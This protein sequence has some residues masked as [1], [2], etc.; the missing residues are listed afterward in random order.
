MSIELNTARFGS[1]QAVNRMEDRAL[2]EGHGVYTDDVTLDRQTH[3]LFLRSTQAHA[4]IVSIDTAAARAMPGVLLVVTGAELTAAGVRHLPANPFLKRAD[5]KPCASSPR[6]PLADKLVRFVGET[7]A[8]VVADSI[9]AARAAV[10]A[11]N[12]EYEELPALPGIAAAMA[13]QWG[14]L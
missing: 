5:G 13:D 3:L 9:A 12:V 14:T 4:K 11:I 10:E 8:A 1:G 2:V 6:L 7:V